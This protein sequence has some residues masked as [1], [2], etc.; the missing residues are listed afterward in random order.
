[1]K[2]GIMSG[3]GRQGLHW[4]EGD[5]RANIMDTLGGA[6]ALTAKKGG[7]SVLTIEAH[8]CSDCKKMIIETDVTK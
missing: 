6:C 1:M 5:K 8:F 3:D 4:K 7:L 2:K